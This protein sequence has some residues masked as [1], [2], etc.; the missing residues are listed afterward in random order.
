MNLKWMCTS[1][2]VFQ[3]RGCGG[4]LMSMFVFNQK[5]KR[6][7]LFIPSILRDGSGNRKPLLTLGVFVN[8]LT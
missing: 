8:A 1:V 4:V 2:Y 7:C 6:K 5:A 3:S